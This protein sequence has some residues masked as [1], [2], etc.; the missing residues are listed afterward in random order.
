MRFFMCFPTV[1]HPGK[2]LSIQF[3]RDTPI[4]YVCVRCNEDVADEN[5]TSGSAEVDIAVRVMA[6]FGDSRGQ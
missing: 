4:R 1:I 2:I 3:A 5:C 6:F